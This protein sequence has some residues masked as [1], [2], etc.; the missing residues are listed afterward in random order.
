[1]TKA[2]ID[3]PERERGERKRE[4]HKERETQKQ[5]ERERPKRS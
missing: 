2:S 5:T 1:M 3:T 4:T